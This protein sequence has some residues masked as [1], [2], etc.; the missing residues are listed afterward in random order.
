MNLL[1]NAVI[2]YKTTL[3]GVSILILVVVKCAQA[4]AVTAD[5]IMAVLAGFGLV[6]SKDA[7]VTGA[8]K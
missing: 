7:N 5:D 1:A 3:V 4:H 6:A 2:S 8:L